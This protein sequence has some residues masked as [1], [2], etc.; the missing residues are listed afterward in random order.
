[1]IKTPDLSDDDFKSFKTLI[2][3]KCGICLHEGKKELVRARLNKRLRQTG[4]K[5]FNDYY[6]FLTNDDNGDELV[7]MLDAIS[8]NKTSFFREIKHFDFLNKEVFPRYASAEYG[9]RLR[10]WSAACSSGEEPYTLAISLLE[11]LGKN[12][13][14]DIKILATD[15]STKVLSEAQRGVYQTDR[16]EDIPKP[17]IRTYFQQGHGRQ[18]GFYKVKPILRNIVSFKRFNLMDKFP[19]SGVFQFVFCRNVMIYFDKKT[20]EKLVNKFYQCIVPGGY[21]M[22]GHSESLTGVNHPFKYIQPSVYQKD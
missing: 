2:Y 3:N 8:T 5:S 6:Q 19:F 15:I 21:L 1:M 20:Q 10:F 13:N 7:V 4:I 17:L 22:I 16:V 9:R 11:F 12:A 18:H 14:F